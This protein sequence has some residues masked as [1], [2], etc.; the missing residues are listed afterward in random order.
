M[1]DACEISRRA[2]G[3]SPSSMAWVEC[4]RPCTRR[5]EVVAPPMREREAIPAATAERRATLRRKSMVERSCFVLT[6]QR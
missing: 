6:E 1:F 2:A 5:K 4:N 3:A